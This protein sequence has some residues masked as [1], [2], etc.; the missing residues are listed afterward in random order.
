MGHDVRSEARCR[1]AAADEAR[2][3]GAGDAVGRLRAAVELAE[4]RRLGPLVARGRRSLRAA[5]VTSRARSAPGRGGLTAREDEVL[6]LVA[7]G[8]S[9]PEIAAALGIK[10][11]TVES[12]VRSATRKLDAPSRLAAVAQLGA[13]DQESG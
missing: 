11:S 12:F 6:R 8:R 13:L 7:S 1:W 10:V 5:G 4:R 9:S 3:A 2:L